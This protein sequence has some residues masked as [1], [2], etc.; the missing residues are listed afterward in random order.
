M[1][2]SIETHIVMRI[3]CYGSVYSDIVEFV[4]C[5]AVLFTLWIWCVK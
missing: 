3:S 2:H 1:E 5:V 4:Q